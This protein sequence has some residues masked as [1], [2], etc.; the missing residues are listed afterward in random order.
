MSRKVVVEIKA[1]V[2]IRMD[3]G[4]T[5]GQVIGETELQLVVAEDCNEKDVGFDIEDIELTDYETLDSK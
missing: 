1:K 2:I 3:D 4:I 5:I